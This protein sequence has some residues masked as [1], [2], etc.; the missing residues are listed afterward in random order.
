[1]GPWN[2]ARHV[3]LHGEIQLKAVIT[4]TGKDL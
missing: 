4:S 3:K 1:M 2:V